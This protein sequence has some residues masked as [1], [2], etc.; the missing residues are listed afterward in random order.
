MNR[1]IIVTGSRRFVRTTIQHSTI[2]TVILRLITY[3]NTNYC[4]FRISMPYNRTS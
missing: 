2:E 3:T 4:E 1:D